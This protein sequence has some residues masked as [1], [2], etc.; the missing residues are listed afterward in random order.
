M[1][2]TG[3]ILCGPHG[4]GDACSKFTRVEDKI[5]AMWVTHFCNNKENPQRFIFIVIRSSSTLMVCFIHDINTYM[6]RPVFQ[7]SSGWRSYYK[8]TICIHPED[9][10]NTSR[11]RL[12]RILWIK[13]IIT[14][15][16]HLLVIYI[17][18]C[19]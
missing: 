18:G 15:N 12:V 1:V 10:R 17:F 16:V 6:F 2:F 3:P 8:N 11:N 9:G 14:I 5:N 13:Y 7:P 4:P 19:E